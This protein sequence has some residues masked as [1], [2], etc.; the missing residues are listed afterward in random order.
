MKQVIAAVLTLGMFLGSAWAGDCTLS[1]EFQLTRSQVL[2]G[3][4]EDPIPLPLPGFRLELVA[5]RNIK[6]TAVTSNEGKYSFGE[7]PAGHY[8]IRIR[9]SGDPFCA[10][11]VKCDEAGC[12]IQR[13]VKLNPKN[14]PEIVY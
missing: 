9:H 5:G 7:V 2:A 14:K 13:Q 10:P 1:N 12:S 3:V 4:L 8:R 11:N 6:D